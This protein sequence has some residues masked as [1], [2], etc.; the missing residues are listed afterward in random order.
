LWSF[1]I[2][3]SSGDSSG[4]LVFCAELKKVGGGGGLWEKDEMAAT[5]RACRL[6]VSLA[7]QCFFFFFPILS[8]FVSLLL[9]FLLELGFLET[10]MI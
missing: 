6:P 9:I 2:S 5:R 3:A 7:V 4:S 10:A 8:K 1:L